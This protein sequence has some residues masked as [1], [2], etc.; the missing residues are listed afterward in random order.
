[1][2]EKFGALLRQSRN[3]A[4]LSI[5]DLAKRINYSKG[6]LSKI[7]NDLKRPTAMLAKLCDRELRTGGALAAVLAAVPVAAVPDEPVVGD[8]GVW[9]MEL[10]G[11]EVRVSE[12]PRRQILAGAGAVL[13]LALVGGRRPELDERAFEVLRT[14]FDQHRVLGTMASPRI[15][16][17]QVIAHLHTLRAL[18]AEN[19]EP[20]RGELLRFAARV[21]EYAGW[22]SQEAGQESA[23]LGWTDRAAGYAAA[24]RDAQLATFAQFRRAEIALYQHDPVRT[25]EL[26]RLAQDDSGAGPRILGLAARVE[27]QGHALAGDVSAC[28]AALDRAA[29]LLSARDPGTGPVL[30]SSSVDDEVS[31]VRGWALY[32]L[33]RPREAAEILGRQVVLIP[34]R[35][36]R[37]RTRFD[38][39]RALAHAVAGDVDEACR[40]ARDLLAD[41]AQVDSATIRLDLAALTRTLRRW[42]N[43]PAVRELLP[44]LAVTANAR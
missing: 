37:A 14:T 18:A 44:D 43:A 25:V 30:G 23:A 13:G 33:G 10:D 31:L 27:A 3:A 4:G 29:G 8:D 16:L 39:R 26:A 21:A 17:A 34:Q 1:M 19:P 28:D 40:V 22:M 35:A 12:L 2:A 38:A 24:G 20:M 11:G 36:R 5:G 15:V 42:H 6:Y 9:I 32:D 7:E 41:A